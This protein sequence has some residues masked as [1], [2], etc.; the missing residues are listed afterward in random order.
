MRLWIDIDGHNALGSGK[1][2]LL[3][4][5]AA[6]K[7]LSAAARQLR[8]SYRLAWEHLRMLEER[9]GLTVVEPQRG[10]P[11]GGGTDLTPEGQ[12]LL[13]AYRNLR[14]EVEQHLQVAYQRHFARWSSPSR[15]TSEPDSGQATVLGAE[16][17]RDPASGP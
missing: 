2:R 17:E 7:S 4:A 11:Q 12:A 9:T 13:E 3:D 1:I 15:E 10:G 16:D 8:M 6:T 14:R 5:I